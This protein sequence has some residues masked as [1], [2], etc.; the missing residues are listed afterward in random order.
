MDGD[1]TT[2]TTDPKPRSGN[3]LRHSSSSHN[4]GRFDIV[5]FDDLDDDLHSNRT[6]NDENQ[7]HDSGQFGESTSL[8]T[9]DDAS[10]LCDDRLSRPRMQNMFDL[11]TSRETVQRDARCQSA[12]R[13]LET[14]PHADPRYVM[15]VHRRELTNPPGVYRTGLY[16]HWWKKVQLPGAMVRDLIVQRSHRD[17]RSGAWGSGKMVF[18]DCVCVCCC[19]LFY[20]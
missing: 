15:Q 10:D 2:S 14:D 6:I 16:A 9:A 20:R 13:L 5:A 4:L 11:S 12:E 1:G 17:R 19:C 8:L 18:C 3:G 7:N